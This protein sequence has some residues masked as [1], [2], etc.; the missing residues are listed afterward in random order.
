MKLS[1]WMVVL[2]VASGIWTMSAGTL[3]AQETPGA[4][5]EGDEATPSREE[6]LDAFWAEQRRVRVLQRR[7][8]EKDHE[9]YL[10]LHVGSIPNDPFLK[11]WPIGLRAGYW[12]NE[13]VGIELGGAYIGDA[14]SSQ[15]ELASFLDDNGGVDVFLRDIHQW[16]ANVM[17]LWA[18]LY[19]KFSFA[20][21]K[22]AHFDWF[23][24]A[25]VGVLGVQQPDEAD[26][27]ERI[28]EIKPEVILSTGWVLHVHQHWAMRLDFRQG[29]FQKESGGVSLPSE[30]SLG[31]S[32]YF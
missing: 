29:I 5:G 27:A 11:Y 16:N 12:I 28:N 1:R 4:T 14:L 6:D 10:S 17:A 24:G 32:Y 25:G 21:R 3:A 23:L 7:L 15:T 13:S 19:G 8:F 2:L 22:L 9:F 31:A 26:L 30:F 20:G 18:P